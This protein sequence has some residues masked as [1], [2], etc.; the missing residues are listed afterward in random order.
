MV[1]LFAFGLIAALANIA[2]GYWLTSRRRISPSVLAR[3]V[4][5]GAGFMLAAVFL[6]VIP[7]AVGLWPD[8]VEI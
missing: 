1:N 4:G 6:E 5:L 7:A 8:R 2:G 3:F